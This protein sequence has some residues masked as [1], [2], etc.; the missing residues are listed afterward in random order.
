MW[1][2][3]QAAWCCPASVSELPYRFL[4]LRLDAS[5]RIEAERVVAEES[6]FST[7][8]RLDEQLV[9]TSSR[10]DRA[11]QQ[12]YFPEVK[13]YRCGLLNHSYVSMTS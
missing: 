3:H 8:S 7:L 5:A 1:G 12:L 9:A 13:G 10:L 11:K 6:G 2:D 4:P